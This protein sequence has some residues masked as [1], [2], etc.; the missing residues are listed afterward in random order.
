MA[1]MTCRE[2]HVKEQVVQ[3]LVSCATCHAGLAGLHR[4]AAH[5][6]AGCASCHAPHTW[7]PE[8]RETCLAC[9]G[10]KK[11]H[12]PGPACAECHDF[13]AAA[14]AAPPQRRA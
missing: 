11:E 14:G 7:S 3:P 8:P 6:D 13:K 1:S 12:N 5:K 9:H 4:K 2:C 10:D